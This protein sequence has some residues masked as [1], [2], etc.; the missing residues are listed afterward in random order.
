MQSFMS[1]RQLLSIPLLWLLSK[2]IEKVM[3]RILYHYVVKWGIPYDYQLRFQKNEST[4]TTISCLMDKLNKVLES[5][6]LGV[7]IFIN[8]RKACN[9]VEHPILYDTFYGVRC[10]SHD[11]LSV[12]WS[13]RQQFIEFH[14]TSSNM[15]KSR[16]GVSKGSN[17]RS[18]LCK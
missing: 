3:Y 7:R 2:V 10:A 15:L 12:Y 1:V 14:Q 11:W 16:C 18:L 5:G 17:L 6:Q 8:T 4:S 13:E 9:S